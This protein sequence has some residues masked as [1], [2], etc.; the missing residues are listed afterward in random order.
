MI[1]AAA[2]F[3]QLGSQGRRTRFAAISSRIKIE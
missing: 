1:F 2:L 3:A